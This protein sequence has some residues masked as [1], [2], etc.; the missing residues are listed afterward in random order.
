[1]EQKRKLKDRCAYIYGD[2]HMATCY[3]IALASPPNGESIN[4][5]VDDVGE[6]SSLQGE[7]EKNQSLY[8]TMYKCTLQMNE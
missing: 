6:T 8:L 7:K 4:Y 5:S 2:I 1:M 3:M